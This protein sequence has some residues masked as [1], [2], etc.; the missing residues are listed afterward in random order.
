MKKLLLILVV[1]MLVPSVVQAQ[2]PRT[3]DIPRLEYQYPIPIV[4]IPLDN[5][6]WD[7]SG[8]GNYVGWLDETGWMSG[9]TVLVA[10]IHY[11]GY[12]CPFTSLDTLQIGDVIYVYDGDTQYTF[13]VKEMFKVDPSEVWVTAP[14]TETT[15]TLIT[16]ADWNGTI[17]TK[18]LVVVAT[19]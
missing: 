9:N 17:Y 11:P 15:L 8:L 16:C 19:E 2:A 4:E 13:Y 14:T 6:Q 3:L 10:H 5:S 1:L 18:R 12:P 7:V